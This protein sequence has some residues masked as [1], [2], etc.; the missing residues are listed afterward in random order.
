MTRI[1]ES[2][3]E[4]FVPGEVPSVTVE[5]PWDVLLGKRMDLA[6]RL[7]A[8]LDGDYLIGAGRGMT[9]DGEDVAISDARPS[10]V[11]WWA[12]NALI[13]VEPTEDTA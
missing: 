9:N 6:D 7:H 1:F 8:A 13:P 5:L 2:T 4:Q 11:V 3:P 12:V 10:E